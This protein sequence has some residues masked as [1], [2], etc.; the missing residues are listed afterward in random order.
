MLGYSFEQLIKDHIEQVKNALGI[1]SVL[2]M[3]SCWFADKRD[4]TD[5]DIDGAQIDLL[6]D[7]RDKAI[8]ICEAKFYSSEFIIDKEYSHRLRNKIAAFKSVVKTRKALVP[9]MITTFGVKRNAY[10]G[11]VQQEVV[12]D[13][14]FI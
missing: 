6:I 9:T 14:L 8:N 5:N 3:Q 11:N 12:L 1:S 7:R 4:L 2:T 13:D 10:S